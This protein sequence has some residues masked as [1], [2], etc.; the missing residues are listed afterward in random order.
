M[1]KLL[2]LDCLV[3]I[4]NEEFYSKNNIFRSLWKNR[5]DTQDMIG[6][7][8][9]MVLMITTPKMQ[10]TKLMTITHEDK[11]VLKLEVEDAQDG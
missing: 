2:A 7:D 11:K 3:F 9:L 1:S 8:N 4:T 10:T 6:H 5:I